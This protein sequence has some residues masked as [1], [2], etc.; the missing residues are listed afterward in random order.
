MACIAADAGADAI[1]VV[2]ARASPRCVSIET[3]LAIHRDFGVELA[4][5]A[6]IEGGADW[7]TL[8]TIWPGPVQVHGD[9]G[10]D[11]FRAPGTSVIRGFRWSLDA[12][13]L[14]D[15]EPG[16]AALLVDGP[17][18]GSGRG[19]DHDALRAGRSTLTKPLI[20]A[21]GLTPD[22]VRGVIERLEPYGVDVSSG[23]ERAPGEK[24]AGAIRAFCQA[25]RSAG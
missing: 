4:V 11:R 20:V 25:A 8:R 24:D 5:V 23:V 7:P 18:G 2:L 15:R 16:V 21:G 17:A 22:S 14:W 12:A 9:E 10:P 13:R 19:F 1:G 6:V 3:A